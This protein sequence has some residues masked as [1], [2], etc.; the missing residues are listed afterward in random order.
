M[1][2]HGVCKIIL[3]TNR[4]LGGLKIYCVHVIILYIKTGIH[5]VVYLI[6]FDKII[7]QY[8]IT[9]FWH[10]TFSLLSA[11][12]KPYIHFNIFF[13]F[14]PFFGVSKQKWNGSEF[15]YAI[16]AI[17][18][19]NLWLF[20]TLSLT[21]TIAILLILNQLLVVGFFVIQVIVL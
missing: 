9:S 2:R 19:S 16:F 14:K 6:S 3:K 1:C 11:R 10:K 13:P 7:R 21:K 17:P 4:Y 12:K 18:L 20:V 5:I 15:Q 8:N